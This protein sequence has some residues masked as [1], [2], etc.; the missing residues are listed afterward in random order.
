MRASDLLAGLFRR[1]RP[2]PAPQRQPEEP[3][4]G[5]LPAAELASYLAQAGRF[6]GLLP[7][8]MQ[9]VDAL[10]QA[11]KRH[12]ANI[13]SFGAGTAGLFSGMDQVVN[14]SVMVL[15]TSAD[16]KKIIIGTEGILQQM[17]SS[18]DRTIDL[19]RQ[20]EDRLRQLSEITVRLQ[21]LVGVLAD[22]S[23]GIKQL[24]RNAEIKAYHAGG[25]GRGFSVIAENM[26][27][28][29]TQMEA[30]AG[31]IPAE[32]GRIRDRLEQSLGG[33]GRAR[34]T[35]LA[36]KE[37][38]DLMRRG[39]AAVNQQNQKLIAE[40]DAI[41]SAARNQMQ[42]KDRLLAG[43]GQIA[44]AAG[45]LG[46]AQELVASVLSTETAEVGQ[47]D[48][49]RKQEE[50]VLRRLARSAAPWIGREL[51]AKN[52]LLRARVLEAE[53]RWRSL[54]GSMAEL[55]TTA[56]EE[57][58]A[59]GAVWGELEEL[60]ANNSAI[61]ANLEATGALL[62]ANMKQT[63]EIAGLL[64]Q[65]DRDLRALQDTWDQ[66]RQQLT[67]VAAAADS[68]I[69]SAG[70]L[71][72]FT[73]EIKLLS[74]YESIEVADMG[75]AGAEF[76]SFVDQTRAL[77]LQAKQDTGRLA[78]LFEDVRKTFGETEL[79]GGQI[80]AL[81]G[82][83]LRNISQAR[84]SLERS[85][86]AAGQFEL[87]GQEAGATIAAQQGRR[88]EIYGVYT[89][90]AGT[91]KQVG[92]Y[93]SRL[94]GLLNQGF[95]VLADLN[96][97]PP[98]L[99]G[100][101]LQGA[102]A[103]GG[104]LQLDLMSDP[105]TL[106][107][108]FLTDSTSNEVAGQIHAGLVQFDDGARVMPAIARSWAVSPD[109]LTWTFHLRKGVRFHNGREL[110]GGDVK[111]SLERLLDPKVKSPNAYFVDMV[112]GG[113]EF[114]AGRSRGVDGIRVVDDHCV[115]IALVRP[116]MPFL[117]NLAV[118]ATA[119]VPREAVASPDF[120]TRPVGAG[121]FMLASWQPGAAIEVAR[122]DGYYEQ[123]V[124][125]GGIRWVIGLDN[126]KR[127]ELFTAGS[128]HAASL[129]QRDRGAL[130]EQ[131]GVVVKSAASL[132]VQ[133][134][135]INVAQDTPFRD[136]LVRQALNCAID[137]QEL[138]DSSELKGEA[139]IARG[140][141][142]PRMEVFNPE[143]VGYPHDPSRAQ[144]LLAQA[145]YPGGLPGEYLL[146]VRDIAAQMERGELVKRQCQEVG[147]RLRI[148][149]LS[150]KE[151]LD[152]AY[153]GHALLSFRG[154]STD[155]GDPDNFLTP[156]FH[157]R[158]FGKPGNTSFLSSPRIDAMLERALAI[159]NPVERQSFYREIEAAVVDE[160]PWVFLY[161]SMRFVAMRPQ[162]HGYRV[163]PFGAPRL[164]DCWLEE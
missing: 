101:P 146:D 135:C 53:D 153:G 143:L 79:I 107:P 66:F 149:P 58:A 140:V 75:D 164:K 6:T 103:A 32:A 55:T 160:A 43:T 97:T 73:D 114:A 138:V 72:S 8:I 77:A 10:N 155:N 157:T 17:L 113:A 132:N 134:L 86:E 133:Y 38:A 39:I 110:T 76:T 122:F 18:V 25:A 154:W 70:Y 83:N 125:L 52:E 7:A 41:Q 28:L 81:T 163:R 5:S 90:Y 30:K 1:Q 80:L 24:S 111:Y 89:A 158:S 22:L 162:L 104:T 98:P 124:S 147:I 69:A 68:L 9:G 130:E 92:Q 29:A 46:V 87:I 115:Q 62:A 31:Q 117:A 151:L 84:W 37:R 36:L 150:W 20:A 123:R 45:R 126:Q 51:A 13:S 34:E 105:I 116:Y 152:R 99:D 23:I 49:V 95:S 19:N 48:F 59:S 33:I 120:A 121:A 78:P 106:D 67:A 50:T 85:G 42:I 47:I 119:V 16:Y 109:G 21:S 71:N 56:G 159:R 88:Q 12:L 40:F 82:D 118:N 54:Q 44:T 91:Y 93:L 137:K 112:R 57:E 74:F 15:D 63:A 131:G 27:R 96:R 144:Q 11:G 4:S 35:A 142:P 64:D 100:H 127:L 65:S 141:F 161:H 2:A 145:G 14:Y 156:L 102:A 139:V 61:S 60:F 148:N 128:L 129:H 108:A 3:P 136:K 26:N 94:A